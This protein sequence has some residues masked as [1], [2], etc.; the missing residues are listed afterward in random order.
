[1]IDSEFGK[2]FSIMKSKWR[3]KACPRPRCGGDLHEETDIY[4]NNGYN[5]FWQCLQCGYRTDIDRSVGKNLNHRR[6]FKKVRR[7]ERYCEIAAKRCSQ[8]VMRLKL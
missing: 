1:M 2:S 7:G 5:K 6:F 8:S 3:L 4:G